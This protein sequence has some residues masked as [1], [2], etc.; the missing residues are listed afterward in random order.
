MLIIKK[1]YE[2]YKKDVFVYLM[3]LT[4]DA[5]LSEDLVS[6]TFLSAIKSIY[7]FKGESS[8]KTWL[9][10]IA[11]NKMIILGSFIGVGISESEWMFYNVI[12]MP[13]VGGIGYFIFRKKSYIVP[14]S[15]FI[16]T[17]V[18]DFIKDIIER[19]TNQMSWKEMLIVPAVWAN[20]YTGLCVLGI[21]IGFLLYIAFKK[22]SK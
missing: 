16:L 12:I 17:Y 13:I 7:R 22:E 9:F 14:I 18:W 20:R 15:I 21:L 10:S 6:E 8:I 3:S 1:I 4:N 2:E 5:C 19:Q 11:R